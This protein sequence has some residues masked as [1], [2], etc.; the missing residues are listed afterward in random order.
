MSLSRRF[1]FVVFVRNHW[2]INIAANDGLCCNLLLSKCRMLTDWALRYNYV[3]WRNQP[4]GVTRSMPTHETSDCG[5]LEASTYACNYETLQHCRDSEN[6]CFRFRDAGCRN[7]T[8]SLG[9]WFNSMIQGNNFFVKWHGAG[10]CSID[11]ASHVFWRLTFWK[12]RLKCVT[13]NKRGYYCVA[14]KKVTHWA[15]KA[16]E[17]TQRCIIASQQQD[18]ENTARIVHLVGT[19]DMFPSLQMWSSGGKIL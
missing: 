14:L 16:W 17:V 7:L 13:F 4:L 2:F 18:C 19:G 5:A 10:I 9:K 1:V 12:F 8:V 15:F 11:E 3:S 6:R